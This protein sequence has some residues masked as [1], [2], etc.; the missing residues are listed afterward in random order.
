MDLKIIS[1]KGSD[2]LIVK[3]PKDYQCKRTYRSS[4]LKD[5]KVIS[6]KGPES[7]QYEHTI[8]MNT[9]V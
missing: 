2:Y 9:S 5:L 3:E 7:H 4:V 8:G 6:V 1:V